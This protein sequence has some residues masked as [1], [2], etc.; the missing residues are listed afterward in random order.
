V[1]GLHAKPE[2]YWERQQTFINGQAK[3]KNSLK[4]TGPLPM[5][6]GYQQVQHLE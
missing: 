6:K 4:A 2:P 3:Q 1:E 5:G